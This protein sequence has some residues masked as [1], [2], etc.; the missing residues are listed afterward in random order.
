MYSDLKYKVLFAFSITLITFILVFIAKLKIP[1][2]EYIKNLNIGPIP[3][4]LV[5]LNLIGFVLP[6]LVSFFFILFVYLKSN[7]K[8][9]GVYLLLVTLYLILLGVISFSSQFVPLQIIFPSQG[10][11]TNIG[12]FSLSLGILFC[13]FVLDSNVGYVR[14]MLVSFPMGF[15]V[16]LTSD[17]TTTLYF[18]TG[19]GISIFGGSGILDGDLLGPMV[20]FTLFY[21]LYVVGVWGSSRRSRN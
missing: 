17:I 19:K 10:G 18:T 15:V 11:G 2:P 13:I 1:D 16:G 4:T 21:L 7:K 20:L 5:K 14:S 12:A 6:A 3:D 9:F 8:R